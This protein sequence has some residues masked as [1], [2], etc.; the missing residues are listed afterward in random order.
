[1]DAT[2][3]PALN[4]FSGSLRS[5]FA[6]RPPL[7]QDELYR[8]TFSNTKTQVYVVSK[9]MSDGFG[10]AA[11]IRHT[12]MNS[13]I[14][15]ELSDSVH[16]LRDHLTLAAAKKQK[17]DPESVEVH[18]LTADFVLDDNRQLWLCCVNDVN[19]EIDSLE[20]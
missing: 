9:W 16:K 20:R 15:E 6:H 19:M 8:A 18:S 12:T 1:M 10:N 7:P 5:P 13:D 3:A 2:L 4:P 14:T 11:P 17:L